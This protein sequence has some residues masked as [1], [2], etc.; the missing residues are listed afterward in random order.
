MSDTDEAQEPQPLLLSAKLAASLLG[1]T[2]R[3]LRHLVD[4]G[5]LPDVRIK[6]RTFIPSASVREFVEN[7]RQSA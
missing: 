5:Q 1:I 3:Q 4:D 7:V 6:N 2:D